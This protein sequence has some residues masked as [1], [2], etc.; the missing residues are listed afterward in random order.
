VMVGMARSGVVAAGGSH[1]GWA[2]LCLDGGRPGSL[3]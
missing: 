3:R 2:R 1:S